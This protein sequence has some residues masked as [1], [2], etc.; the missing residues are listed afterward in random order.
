MPVVYSRMDPCPVQAPDVEVA[1]AP[2]AMYVTQLPC[3][4]DLVVQAVPC[5]LPRR[6]VRLP[7]ALLQYRVL[8]DLPVVAP[9]C[10]DMP[11]DSVALGCGVSAYDPRIDEVP[12]LEAVALPHMVCDVAIGLFHWNV[13][14]GLPHPVQKDPSHR[15]HLRR[16]LESRI[17]RQCDHV[18]LP[19]MPCPVALVAHSNE[20]VRTAGASVLPLP[21]VV[22]LKMVT[23]STAPASEAVSGLHIGLDVLITQLLTLLVLF[24]FD[25]RIPD[26]LD[27]EG[28]TLDDDPRDGQD[29]AYLVDDVLVGPDL[30]LHRWSEPAPRSF[31][32]VAPLFPVTGLAV[33][34]CPPL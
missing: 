2:P 12:L 16:R 6:L 5:D 7:H 18:L 1:R 19:L 23:R 21:D 25:S 29:G 24:P 30:R 3:V 32:V 8:V 4:P 26:L 33:P 9:S 22:D 27:V 10:D 17:C 20:V 28:C 31:P 13:G 34:P 15:G 11:E 14:M